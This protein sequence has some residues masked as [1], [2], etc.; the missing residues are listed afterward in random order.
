MRADEPEGFVEVRAHV[1]PHLMM[2][3]RPFVSALRAAVVE[4][5]SDARFTCSSSERLRRVLDM[6]AS[7]TNKR[8]KRGRFGGEATSRNRGDIRQVR[9]SNYGLST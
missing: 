5:M 8:E 1:V 9:V 4:M 7:D 2:P 3:V 6:R